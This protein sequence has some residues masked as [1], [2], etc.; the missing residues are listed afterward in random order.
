M[1]DHKTTAYLCPGQGSQVVGM[2]KAL[3]ETYPVARR[4]FEQADDILGFALSELCFDGPQEMLTD[5]INAQPALYVTGVAALR[6]LLD[7][8]DAPFEPAYVAGHSLGELTA[9]TTAGALD[10]A[11]GVRLVRRRGELMRQA[12]QVSP[13]GMVAVL[14]LDADQVAVLCEQARAA[15]GGVLVVANDNCPGQVVISGDETGLEAGM[16]AARQAGAKRVIRL[17]VSIAAHS[18][19]M[20]PIAEAFG[21]SVEATPFSLPQVPVVGNINA[22]PLAGV[23]EIRAELRAQL[24][25]PVRWTDSVRYMLGQGVTTFVELGSKDVLIGLLRRIDKDA[26]G[27]MLDSPQGIEALLVGEM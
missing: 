5:T 4:T 11:D 17:A 7:E 6:A 16:T 12:D 18:P 15:S 3:A 21:Q 2:G 10:F 9:L 24:T 1:L 27:V 14:G 13:G 25:L 20:G 8:L 22:R 23:D 19:L 26:T